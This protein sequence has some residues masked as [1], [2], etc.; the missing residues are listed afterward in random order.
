VQ[1]NTNAL[2]LAQLADELG[3]S[4]SAAFQRAFKTWTG[5][6]PGAYRQHVARPHPE[7]RIK[8]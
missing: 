4:T 5:S 2:S 6:P 7:D 1:L 8:A 3:F